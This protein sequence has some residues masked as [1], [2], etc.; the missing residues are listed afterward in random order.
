MRVAMWGQ[1][2]MPVLAGG[3]G[4]FWLGGDCAAI[5]TVTDRPEAFIFATPGASIA[6]FYMLRP[7]VVR[8]YS[9]FISIHQPGL[10]RGNL[11]EK[12]RK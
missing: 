6:P 1:R 8:S 3:A 7:R 9:K 11:R 4:G 5:K 12:G 2:T 10:Q